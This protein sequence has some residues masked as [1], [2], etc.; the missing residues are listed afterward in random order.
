MCRYPGCDSDKC[1]GKKLYCSKHLKTPFSSKAEV[2]SYRRGKR[3]AARSVK[4]SVHSFQY[5]GK[6]AEE[7]RQ[8]IESLM[9]GADDSFPWEERVVAVVDL[10]S[11][12]DSVDARDSLA[13]SERNAKRKKTVKR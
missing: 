6:E 4:C 2:L 10:Q 13:F 8:G 5:H 1:S 3:D 9:V 11:L 7:L 12:L